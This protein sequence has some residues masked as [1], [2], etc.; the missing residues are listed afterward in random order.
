MSFYTQIDFFKFSLEEEMLSLNQNY[1]FGFLYFSRFIW[2][3]FNKVWCLN[4]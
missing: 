4:R 2:L 3:N 1:L